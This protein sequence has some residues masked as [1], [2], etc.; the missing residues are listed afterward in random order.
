MAFANLTPNLQDIF[1]QINDRLRKLESGPNSA[2]YSADTAQSTASSAQ[3]TAQQ[4]YVQAIAAGA[5]A[6]AAAYTA[7][8]ALA[9]ANGKN[10]V[11]YSTSGPSGSGTDGDIWF[12]TDG[13][14]NVLYQYILKSGTWTNSPIT[15]TVIASLDAGKITTGTLTSIAIYAGSSG[16]FQVS[17]AGALVAT[18][19]SVQG[20]VTASAGKI[21]GFSIVGNDYLNYG[22]TYIYGNSSSSTYAILDI[23]KTIG[24]AK[25][26]TTG[27]AADSLY[28][29]GGLQVAGAAVFSSTTSFTGNGN[30]VSTISL[31]GGYGVSSG[32]GPL[33]TNTYDL[34]TGTGNQWN[35]IYLHN[36]PIVNSDSRLKTNVNNS[37]LGLNFINALRP[38]NY[39][40]ING[41]NQVEVDEAGNPIIESTDSDNKPVYK[42]ASIAGKRTHYGFIAQEVKSALD[43]AKVGDFA[44]WVL[45]DLT[46]PDS[47]QSLS[48]EQ[49][50]APLVKAVQELTTRITALEAK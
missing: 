3:T 37:P 32:W 38:V 36:S 2:Q 39:Q 30:F 11:H 34:G 26:Q 7:G 29:S 43:A 27:T 4:A 46:N 17:A 25:I 8:V 1:N 35:H 28:S 14:G 21:G 41:G 15:S 22:T 44:G 40:F 12:Q 48:Y 18:N 49:F 6:T 9:S 5:Q 42:L 23:S 16:Q 13:S 45:G 19:A 31:S 24:A 33:S 50:I 47:I 10:Q 20:T